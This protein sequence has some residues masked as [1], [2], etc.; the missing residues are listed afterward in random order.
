MET[1]EIT[2]NLSKEQVDEIINSIRS[3]HEYCFHE[4]ARNQNN[5]QVREELLRKFMELGDLISI[6]E[7][8]RMKLW[9]D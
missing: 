9:T 1:K 6:F 5:P 2:L 3:Q 8:E 7:E 4:Q